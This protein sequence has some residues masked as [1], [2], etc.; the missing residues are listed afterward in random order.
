MTDTPHIYIG[1]SG[2]SY[3][4]GAG[5]WN[6][7]F[8]PPGTKNELE[9]YSRFFNT[10]EL[11][12]SFYRPPSPAMAANWVK[13]VPDGFLFT[14]I[15][16]VLQLLCSVSWPIEPKAMS[17][18]GSAGIVRGCQLRLLARARASSDW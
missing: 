17:A 11:N 9:F 6:G 14:V 4:Q 18:T 7:Y 8:Y 3:P 5:T 16:L 15:C 10:V 12:S 2:W 13:K 1:T